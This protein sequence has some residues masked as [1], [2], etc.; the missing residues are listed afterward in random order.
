M[1]LFLRDLDTNSIS[2]LN[3]EIKNEGKIRGEGDN[4]W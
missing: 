3:K 4:K 1:Y 2:N